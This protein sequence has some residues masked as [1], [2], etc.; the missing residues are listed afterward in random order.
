MKAKL[1]LLLSLFTLGLSA[2]TINVHLTDGRTLKY[3]SSEVSYVDFTEQGGQQSESVSPG[4]FTATDGVTKV[5][6]QTLTTTEP[7]GWQTAMTFAYSGGQ[8]NKAYVTEGSSSQTYTSDIDITYSPFTVSSVDNTGTTDKYYDFSF[9]SDGYATGYTRQLREVKEAGEEPED[10]VQVA[11]FTYDSEGHV[12]EVTVNGMEGSDAYTETIKLTWSFGNLTRI[13]TIDDDES[14]TTYTFAYDDNAN[15]NYPGQWTWNDLCGADD[16]LW[17]VYAGLFGKAS[18]NHPVSCQS[19]T[20]G[21]NNSTY[22][23]NYNFTYTYNPDGTIAF[24]DYT[25]TTSSDSSPKKGSQKF[26]Y[27]K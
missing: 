1:T 4:V 7:Y 15:Q 25:V 3:N 12:T 11:T 9:N 16:E 5:Y 8:M 18:K 24:A 17:L 2:Q 14:R 23:E 27:N 20:I 22:V 13:E 26:T 19:V 21:E 6:L 10:E